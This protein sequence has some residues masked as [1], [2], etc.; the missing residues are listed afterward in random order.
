MGTAR[1]FSLLIV[2][3]VVL[4]QGSRVAEAQAAF[5]AVRPGQSCCPGRDDECTMPILDT[6]CYCDMFCNRTDVHD[7]C[8]DYWDLCLGIAPPPGART[9]PP[10]IPTTTER[11]PPAFTSKYTLYYHNIQLSYPLF[12]L[13]SYCRSN[14]VGAKI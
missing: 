5:C 7:C 2:A 1:V 11:P 13:F 14:I 9:F 4:L 6:V 3:C 12:S 8:P 10:T